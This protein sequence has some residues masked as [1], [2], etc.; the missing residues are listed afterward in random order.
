[1]QARDAAREPPRGG[2]SAVPLPDAFAPYAWA[3]TVAEVAARHGLDPVQVLKFDQ[4]TPPL[5]GVAQVPLAESFATLNQ[6]PDGALPRPA[7]GRGGLRRREQPACERRLGADRRRRGRRRPHPALR[8]HVPRARPDGVDHPADLLAL[9]HRDAAQRCRAGR[10]AGGREPALAL[11][12]RE[13]DRAWSRRRPSSSSSRAAIP[14]QRSSSTRRTS[15]TA[16]SRS[17]P[18]STSART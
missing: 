1:M 14:T 3:A 13:P 15:S 2:P 12:P 10:R 9:P 7:R 11:Q 5:P 18:G 6:Y 17:S 4:N 16:A 8:A